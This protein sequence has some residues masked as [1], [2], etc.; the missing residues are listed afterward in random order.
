MKSMRISNLIEKISIPR[1]A[2]SKGEKTAKRIISEEL[3]KLGYNVREEKV[4][5]IK[6]ENYYK[7]TKLIKIWSPTLVISLSIFFHPLSV[8]LFAVGCYLISKKVYPKIEFKFAKGE[9]ANLIARKGKGKAHKLI[10]CGHYDSSKITRSIMRKKYEIVNFLFQLMD[11]VFRIFLII[12]FLRGILFFFPNQYLPEIFQVFLISTPWK[13]LTFSLV[14]IFLLWGS[15]RSFFILISPKECSRGADDNASGIVSMIEVARKIRN[16]TSKIDVELIF[17]AAE[18]LGGWGSRNWIKRHLKH[19]DKKRTYFLNLDCVGRG[20]S[21]FVTKGFGRIIKQ[22]SDPFLFKTIR[23]AAFKL[24]YE[25][26]SYWGA[27]SDDI[28]L[29]EKKLRVCS[30]MRANERKI[31]WEERIRR[32]LLLIPIDNSVLPHVD[33]IHSKNDTPEFVNEKK[34]EEVVEIVLE[35]IRQLNE[36]ISSRRNITC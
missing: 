23:D 5:Y 31:R 15:C 21:I 2:G 12:L 27:F 20:K 11:F 8:F 14:L 18:E 7:F 25:L 9:T 28:K 6:S 17:F 1:C 26:K 36:N 3:K 33:W 10:I 22:R 29:F 34:I 19:L 24:G 30:L 13:G 4:R 16:R 32:K 35:F